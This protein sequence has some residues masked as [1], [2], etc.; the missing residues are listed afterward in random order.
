MKLFSTIAVAAPLLLASEKDFFNLPDEYEFRIQKISRVDHEAKWP[1]SVDK[2]L[3]ACVWG[4][5]QRLT[6]F[7]EDLGEAADDPDANPRILILTINPFDLIFVNMQHRD[8]F[9]PDQTIEQ[10][11]EA[12]A[13]LVTVALRLCDQPPGTVVGPSEL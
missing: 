5:G 9:A 8:L 13:P 11:I 2:G 12:V 3:L 4:L 1:F 10:R 6:Y 7:V